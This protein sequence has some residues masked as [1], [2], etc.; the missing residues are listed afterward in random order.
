MLFLFCVG[1]FISV[2]FLKQPKSVLLVMLYVF[3]RSAPEV[4]SI[5]RGYGEIIGDTPIDV[6]PEIAR[7]ARL[8]HVQ[9]KKIAPRDTGISFEG[10]DLRYAGEKNLLSGINLNIA[11]LKFVCIVGK[12]G[13]GKSTILD[14]I[15]GFHKPI[16]GRVALGGVDYADIDWSRWR[17]NIGLI[18][19]ESTVISGSWVDN[20]AFLDENPDRKKIEKLLAEV[21]LAAHVKSLPKFLDSPVEARG[22][23]LSA[24][25]RQRL[26]L[27]RCLYRDPGLLLLD[28][29]VSNLDAESESIINK[30]LLR[31]KGAKT[32]IVITH[33]ES[34]MEEADNIYRTELDGFVSKIK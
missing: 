29:P 2:V 3:Y 22:A 6:T 11:P 25:Q 20:V 7:W 32:V 1:A 27:A 34:L 15:C 16:G 26:L 31:L 9:Q 33:R 10:V 24:G 18:R 17:S 5:A 8:G 23:N 12:N 4:I 14:V 30:L 13:T 19:P 21:G 28:E